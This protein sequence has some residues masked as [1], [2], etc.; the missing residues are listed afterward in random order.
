MQPL[1][2]QEM[3]HSGIITVKGVNNE[4]QV[5]AVKDIIIEQLLMEMRA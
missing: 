2:P 1:K 5:I 3:K 4:G